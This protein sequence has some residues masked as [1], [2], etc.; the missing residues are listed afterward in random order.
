MRVSSESTVTKWPAHPWYKK[1]FNHRYKLALLPLLGIIP[2]SYYAKNVNPQAEVSGSMQQISIKTN[3]QGFS[4]SDLNIMCIEAT[5]WMMCLTIMADQYLRNKRRVAIHEVGHLIG[6]RVTQ[7]PIETEF[8]RADFGGGRLQPVGGKTDWKKINKND[9]L[10]R[11]CGVLI[12]CRA[13]E[14]MERL[15]YGYNRP[16]DALSDRCAVL[17]GSISTAKFFLD[18]P[19]KLLDFFCFWFRLDKITQKLLKQVDPKVIEELADRLC[20]DHKWDADQIQE[21]VEEFDLDKFP[22]FEEVIG[23]VRKILESSSDVT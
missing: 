21:L 12:R 8:I 19:E 14:S 10:K 22:P 11:M 23:E 6:H 7:S 1:V 3:A 9:A 16:F 13:G 5:L 20:K 17:S 4:K 2:G 18:S 15:I